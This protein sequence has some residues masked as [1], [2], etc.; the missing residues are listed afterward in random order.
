MAGELATEG[1]RPGGAFL[2]MGSGNGERT[3]KAAR[4][5]QRKLEAGGER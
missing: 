5:Y 3:R 2:P 1:G 4:R